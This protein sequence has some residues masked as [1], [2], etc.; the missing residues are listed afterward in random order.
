MPLT[1]SQSAARAAAADAIIIGVTETTAGPVPSPGSEDVNAALGGTLPA[2][3]A[4]LGATGKQDEVT[5]IASGSQLAAP[6]I[7][8]VGLGQQEGNEEALRRAAGAG[9]RSLTA[10]RVVVGALLLVFG[11]QWIRKAILRASGHKALHDEDRIFKEQLAAAHGQEARRSFLAPDWYGFTLSF[12][13]VLL[14]GLEV[15]FIVLTFGA[16]AKNVGLATIAAAAAVVLIAAAGFA[17]KA[18]LARVP[19]NTMKF[20]VGI[21][22]TSFGLFWGGEGAGAH[23]PGSDA[24]LLVIIP[25][26]ALFSIGLVALLRQPGSGEGGA[27]EV[28]APVA[29]SAH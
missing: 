11:L 4:A 19:E 18:P 16:N 5:R 1:T 15:V 25:A 26:I 8:A 13:G 27:A 22:L 28:K 6:L 17:I 10:L 2:T 14:E 3:L 9:V 24:A 29:Q 23:W 21:M 20:V 12:K 7:V